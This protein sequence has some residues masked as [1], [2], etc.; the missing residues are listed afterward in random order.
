MYGTLWK[1][2]DDRITPELRC[3]TPEVEFLDVRIETVSVQECP[4]MFSFVTTS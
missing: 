2:L 3:L 4:L 1:F